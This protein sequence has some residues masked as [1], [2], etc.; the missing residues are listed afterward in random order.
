MSEYKKNEY[1]FKGILETDKY[2]YNIIINTKKYNLNGKDTIYSQYFNFG[3]YTDNNKKKTC[4]DIYVMYPIS[5]DLMNMGNP[6]MAQLITTHFD[7]RCSVD[8]KLQRGEGTHHLLHTAMY[9]VLKMCP[10]IKGFEIND[11]STRNCDN[12]TVITLSYFSITQYG[13]TWYEKNFNAYIGDIP[14][15]N[16]YREIVDKIFEKELNWELFNTIYL[17]DVNKEIVKTLET[18]KDSSITYAD[19]FKKIHKTGV[20][21][22]CILI[23]PWIDEFMLSTNL[24]NYVLYTQWIIPIESIKRVTL[25][26]Y[27]KDFY[28]KI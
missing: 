5:Q 3:S 1:L 4:V 7:E 12:K 27:K 23:Q 21:N 2:S 16:K 11:A 14:K 25:K 15:R 10:F 22:A 13:K 20:S 24:R 26:N 17:R 18:I 28:G 6:T 9:F 19:F 8:K